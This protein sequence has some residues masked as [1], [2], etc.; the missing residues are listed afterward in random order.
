MK[1]KSQKPKSA[2]G[3]ARVTVALLRRR[4]RNAW[5]GENYP[6]WMMHVSQPPL[7]HFPKGES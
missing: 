1:R 5:R 6:G 2:I 7:T 3:R 4:I